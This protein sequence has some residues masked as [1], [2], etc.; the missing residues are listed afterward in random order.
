MPL[1]QIDCVR[2][3]ED[4]FTL[5]E[6]LLASLLVVSMATGVATLPASARRVAERSRRVTAVQ[7]IATAELEAIRGGAVSITGVDYLDAAGRSLGSS[8]SPLGVFVCRWSAEPA[9]F[10]PSHVSV[11]R[12]VASTVASD[13]QR[14][15]AQ[16]PA[17]DD[18]RLVA[19]VTGGGA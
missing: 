10:D 12:I 3:R 5:T 15:A 8:P 14:D 18:V 4:G 17:A 2:G 9:P 13:R 11:V 6:V 1:A 7:V 16:E 19:L